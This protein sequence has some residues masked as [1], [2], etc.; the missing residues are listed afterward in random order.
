MAHLVEVTGELGG[1]DFVDKEPSGEEESNGQQNQC[2]MRIN[3]GID[4][5]RI[6]SHGF[7]TNLLT[8]RN[9]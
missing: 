5:A 1:G 7:Q 6:P 2:Q 8:K 3:G 9:G 4:W